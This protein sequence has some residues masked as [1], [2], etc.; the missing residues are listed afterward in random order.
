MQMILQHDIFVP[1]NSTT[2]LHTRAPSQA[3][4][5]ASQVS[6]SVDLPE[7]GMH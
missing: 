3:L 7:A 5:N 4:I 1:N 6:A 2:P